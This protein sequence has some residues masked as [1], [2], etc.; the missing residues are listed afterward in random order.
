[1]NEMVLTSQMRVPLCTPPPQERFQQGAE[2]VSHGAHGSTELNEYL[3][4]GNF[5]GCK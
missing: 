3:Q 4:A 1:M 5:P 2:N